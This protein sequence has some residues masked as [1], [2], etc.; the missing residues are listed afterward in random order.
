[1]EQELKPFKPSLE[2]NNEKNFVF[3]YVNGKVNIKISV[4]KKEL[5][6]LREII[7]QCLEDVTTAINENNT[8]T[9]EEVSE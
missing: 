3:S 1:M 4:G 7:E 9:E 8:Q 6:D 2:I 5:S